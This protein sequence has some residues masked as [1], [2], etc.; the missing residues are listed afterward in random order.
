MVHIML[1]DK[2]LIYICI[3]I[4]V[5]YVHI[6]VLCIYILNIYDVKSKNKIGGNKA[7]GKEKKGPNIVSCSSNHILPIFPIIFFY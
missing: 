5:F 6:S 4:L 1:V 2:T 3:Y 7:I